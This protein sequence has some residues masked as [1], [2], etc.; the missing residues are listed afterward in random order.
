MGA[1]VSRLRSINPALEDQRDALQ[2]ILTSSHFDRAPNLVQLLRYICEQSFAGQA[3]SIKEYNIAVEA[4][5]RSTDFDQKKDSIVRV[6]AHR[7]RKRLAEYYLGPG[8]RDPV[9]I[10]LPSGTYIPHFSFAGVTETR[11]SIPI[12]YTP[13]YGARAKPFNPL[14]T[15]LEL[16]EEGLR[17]MCGLPS[18]RVKDRDGVLWS[19]DQYVEGGGIFTSTPKFIA[20]TRTPELYLRRREG[21]F[22]YRIPLRPGCYELRLHFA[23]TVFGEGNIA[24]GGESS[25]L[26]RV[27][28]NG[29][30]LPISDV[31]TEAG[32]PNTA[33]VR[34][35]RDVSPAE[36]G[37]LHLRFSKVEENPFLNGLELLPGIPGRLLPVRIAALSDGFETESGQVWTS[38]RYFQGGQLVA[39]RE[40]VEGAESGHL[41]AGERYGRFTYSIPVDPRGR[42]CLKLHFAEMWF[43]PGMPGGGG[44]G[45]RIFQVSCNGKSLLENFD[46]F[47]AAGAALRA[48]TRTFHDLEPTS[49]GHLNL[50]FLPWRH[51]ALI[52]GIEVLEEPIW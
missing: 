27:M 14:L 32:G 45:S 7:L 6:E 19:G 41:F 28:C 23:E 30:L 5:G 2:R 9:A 44:E 40:T 15:P 4:L 29:D 50:M 48:V 12:S 24:G 31:L 52:H 36:D 34:V 47:R 49:D 33:L 22:T 10:T 18:S 21:E 51:Y 38:D 39:R 46:V 26:M 35:F 42:Y 3:E 11:K 16:N 43:G 20:R 25:R 13:V 17:I 1:P 8:A 37:Y